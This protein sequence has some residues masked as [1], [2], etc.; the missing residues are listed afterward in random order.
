VDLFIISCKPGS[1][2][3]SM[4]QFHFNIFVAGF[5]VRGVLRVYGWVILCRIGV[6][7]VW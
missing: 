5:R 4:P 3:L 2:V 1:M 6:R 7:E